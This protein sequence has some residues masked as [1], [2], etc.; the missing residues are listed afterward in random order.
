MCESGLR[1]ISTQSGHPRVAFFVSGVFRC[2][3]VSSAK[4]PAR[5]F[6]QNVADNIKCRTCLMA[7]GWVSWRRITQQKPRKILSNLTSES[8]CLN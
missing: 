3:P 7:E 8:K 5:A 6:F 4:A 2:V 1:T